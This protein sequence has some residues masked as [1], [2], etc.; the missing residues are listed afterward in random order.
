M[1]HAPVLAVTW[2]LAPIPHLQNMQGCKRVKEGKS[3]ATEK[4][5]S[6]AEGG[7]PVCPLHTWVPCMHHM[8]ALRCIH[9]L[10]APYAEYALHALYTVHCT[11]YRLYALLYALCVQSEHSIE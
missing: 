7:S 11:L 9:A 3:V 8:H 1:W 5:R 10:C 2:P 6:G 4:A